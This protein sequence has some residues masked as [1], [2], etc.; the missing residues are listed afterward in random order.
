[1]S[2][3]TVSRSLLVPPTVDLGPPRV[4]HCLQEHYHIYVGRGKDPHA[5]TLGLLGNPFRIGQD[6]TRLQVIQR[7]ESYILQHPSLQLHLLEIR[8]LVLGCWCHPHPCHGDVLV[9]LANPVD[10]H[11]IGSFAT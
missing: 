6:G 9:R 11:A 4:V 5:G 8:G 10:V 7:Y 3:T 2:P 1:M